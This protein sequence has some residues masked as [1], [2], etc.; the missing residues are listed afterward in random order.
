METIQ[1]QVLS[2]LY[3]FMNNTVYMST[4]CTLRKK[5]LYDRNCTV[6]NKLLALTYSST[7]T[8]HSNNISSKSFFIRG[9]RLMNQGDLNRNMN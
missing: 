4:E 9:G 5:L 1:V 6:D 3:F 2:C 8:A 7:S